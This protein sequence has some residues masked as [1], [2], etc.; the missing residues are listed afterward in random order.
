MVFSVAGICRIS[1]TRRC[2]SLYDCHCRASR[3]H[4]ISKSS[5]TACNS[6]SF[7]HPA[8]IKSL[9]GSYTCSLHDVLFMTYLLQC[10]RILRVE[11]L[12]YHTRCWKV[13]S[14]TLANI[15]NGRR[16]GAWD[17]V[18]SSQA[19]CKLNSILSYTRCSQ[20]YLPSIIAIT[21]PC[22]RGLSHLYGRTTCSCSSQPPHTLL[23][24]QTTKP[25]LQ[26]TPIMASNT[27]HLFKGLT[28]SEEVFDGSDLR[29]AIVHG[30]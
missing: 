13:T 28:A 5:A 9:K 26:L 11:Q 24:S 27:E 2:T 1:Y 14:I 12:V 23:G 8:M 25:E 17:N 4:L 22:L 7:S 6:I 29:I 21:C 10:R 30:R 19:Y 15:A 16:G 20:C 3:C 18:G